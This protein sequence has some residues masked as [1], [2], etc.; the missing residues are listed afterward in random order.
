L[1]ENTTVEELVDALR[2]V[3]LDTETVI[4]LMKAIDKAGSLYGTLVLL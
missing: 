4:Q 1:Q 2:T 3:G